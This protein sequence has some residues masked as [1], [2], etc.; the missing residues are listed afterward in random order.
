MRKIWLPVVALIAGLAFIAGCAP[1]AQVQVNLDKEFKLAIGQMAVVKGEN[2]E[3]K[4]VEVTGDSRCPTGVECIWAGEVSCL[5]EVTKTGTGGQ[6]QP[7]TRTDPGA[8]AG[9][10]TTA[11]LDG[12][13]VTFT[14][15][16]YPR[17]GKQIQQ[18][19]YRLVMTVRRG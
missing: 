15:T 1:P 10:N 18:S 8:G 13:E 7:V 5:V 19:D 9:D 3:I 6:P 17:A 16:P 4:F 14:V 11:S 2:L 12:Y